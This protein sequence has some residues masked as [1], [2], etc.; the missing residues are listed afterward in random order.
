MNLPKDFPLPELIHSAD[1]RI[2]LDALHF[3]AEAVYDMLKS[4]YNP[5][6][7]CKVFIKHSLAFFSDSEK[8]IPS[9]TG[10]PL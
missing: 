8:R 10:N 4:L 6:L 1:E 2:P 9:F 7:F 5:D 3:G